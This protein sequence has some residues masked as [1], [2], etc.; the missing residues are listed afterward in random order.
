[1]SCYPL[2]TRHTSLFSSYGVMKQSMIEDS[3]VSALFEIILEIDKFAC[4]ISLKDCID[5]NSL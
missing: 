5:K 4:Q 2:G 3:K 1:M